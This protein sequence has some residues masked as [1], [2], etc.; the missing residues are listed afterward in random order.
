[1]NKKHLTIQ[2]LLVTTL[3]LTLVPYVNAAETTEDTQAISGTTGNEYLMIQHPSIS[4]S[5][6]AWAQSFNATEGNYLTKINVSLT[7]LGTVDAVIACRLEAASAN[8]YNSGPTGTVLA[9]STNTINSDDLELYDATN[10][11]HAVTFY[12]NGAYRLTHNSIY[13]FVVYCVSTTPSDD[14][15]NMVR[16]GSRTTPAPHAG[17][18]S[19]YYSGA[20]NGPVDTTDL[21]FAVISSD[22]IGAP[23]GAPTAAPASTTDLATLINQFMDFLVPLIIM[24]IPAFLI[25][26]FGGRGKWPLLIGLAVGTAL[27]YVFIPT[28]PV[29]L[30]FLVAVGIIGMA[31]SDVSSGG[32]YT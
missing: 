30:V 28:F 7:K 31:Y 15:D 5:H 21:T 26:F 16:I 32:S 23:T 17:Y 22:T 29:W 20:W 11:T 14:Y 4:A 18:A 1:M 13:V 8:Q 3:L 19:I 27:G 24:L 12:F 9:T 25:W 2:L 10:R 6:S